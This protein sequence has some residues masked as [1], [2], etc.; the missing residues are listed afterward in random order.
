MALTASLNHLDQVFQQY[1]F[2]LRQ[3][4]QAGLTR[5]EIEQQVA[6]FPW[7]LPPDLYDLYQWHNG[8]SG[9]PQ[10]MRLTDRLIRLKNKWHGELSGRENELRLQ[11]G[12][13]LWVGQFLPLDYA[14][15]GHRHLK[16]GKCAI[17]LLPIF[18]IGDRH[19]KFYG[20]V[21]LDPD[22]PAVYYA[23]GTGVPPLWVTEDFLAKQ[24]QFAQ[25]SD[26]IDVLTQACQKVIQPIT[27]NSEVGDELAV[28]YI[29]HLDPLM[30]ML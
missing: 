1:N 19:R 13:R 15:A 18:L 28:D 4:L 10:K 21:R 24:V 20:M 25:L 17:D 7:T 26:L 23:D 8:L 29:V 30:E 2:E 16:L 11:A 14:L 9:K 27:T 22:H 3:R 6:S 5:A 12:E